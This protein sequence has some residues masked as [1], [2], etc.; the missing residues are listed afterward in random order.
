[1]AHYET[2]SQTRRPRFGRRIAILAAVVVVVAVAWSVFWF[3]AAAYAER[4]FLTVLD[5]ASQQGVVLDCTDR[6]ISGYP[7]RIELR[8]GEATS[9][10][11]PDATITLDGLSAVGL[12]YN[13]RH[14]IVGFAGPAVISDGDFPETTADWSLARASISVRGDQ[15]GRFSLSV[16][17]PRIATLGSEVFAARLAELHVRMDPDVSDTVDVAVRLGGVEPAVDGPPIDATLVTAI[18]GLAG[19]SGAGNAT[20]QQVLAELGGVPIELSLFSLQ[21]GEA[22]LS[23]AG[24]LTVRPDGYL[25]GSV[26]V[27]VAADGQSLPYLDTLAA[28]R[29]DNLRSLID[30]ILK[31]GRPTEIEGVQ[32]RSFPLA[33]S[34]GRVS[35]GLF[36][37]GRIPPVP[38]D[39]IRVR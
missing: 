31:L 39:A 3:V 35:A 30:T 16:E 20:A 17:D 15:L 23:A 34:A 28:G 12:I 9:L 2:G 33:I 21:A 13:P 18:E 24:D 32:A 14:V 1:M 22:R 10:T 5:D 11:L 26:D 29:A 7:F 36:P 37:L 6:T 25:D 27:A 8:C 4:M 19:L 38:V